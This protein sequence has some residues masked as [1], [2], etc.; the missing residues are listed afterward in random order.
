MQTFIL[1]TEQVMPTNFKY[2]KEYI[3]IYKNDANERHTCKAIYVGITMATGN[4]VFR[5]PIDGGIRSGYVFDEDGG[6]LT[7]QHAW[8]D[9]GASG[10]SGESGNSHAGMSAYS[11]NIGASAHSEG[12][13]GSDYVYR[14]RI[15][16]HGGSSLVERAL[17]A[18]RVK[19]V[20]ELAVQWKGM[21][22]SVLLVWSICYALSGTHVGLMAAVTG[23]LLEIAVRDKV[24]KALG[25]KN[26]N[27]Q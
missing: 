6:Y 19:V 8:Q 3:T 25:F 11:G 2:G 20:K 13:S 9:V 17:D 4:R 26:K 5:F 27:K 21:A 12:Y 16:I 14:T 10:V 18:Y 7:I 24:M 22:V 1:K 23:I 15:Y